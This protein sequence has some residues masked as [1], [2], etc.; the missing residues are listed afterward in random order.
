MCTRLKTEDSLV[1]IEYT[2]NL[3]LRTQLFKAQFEVDR[4]RD[5][6]TYLDD[7]LPISHTLF[8][9][10][11]KAVKTGSRAERVYLSHSD[12]DYIYEIG[13]L[14][15]YSVIDSLRRKKFTYK[16]TD[17]AGFY[18]IIDKHGCVLYPKVMQVKLAPMLG[19]T[20]PEFDSTF[21]QIAMEEKT[22][23][24]LPQ[25]QKKEDTVIAMVIGGWP[26]EIW[27]QFA[28][29]NHLWCEDI[30]AEI[31][32]CKLYLVPK[33]HPKSKH[34]SVEWRISFSAPEQVLMLHL[35]DVHRKVY[36]LCKSLCNK[37]FAEEIQSYALKTTLL[38]RLDEE[39]EEGL[40]A[41][42]Y[43][44]YY[45]MKGVF[46]KLLEFY[47]RKFLPNYFLP[48]S[49]ILCD[50]ED[51]VMETTALKIN[52][53]INNLNKIIIK[54]FKPFEL[55]NED[56]LNLIGMPI[57]ANLQS[58]WWLYS[59][60]ITEN[61]ANKDF[62]ISMFNN[63][64]LNDDYCHC[65]V[66]YELYN[67]LLFFCRC[68]REGGKFMQTPVA[69]KQKVIKH[70]LALLSEFLKDTSVG[71][72]LFFDDDLIINFVNF[73]HA[74]D[75]L[76]EAVKIIPI[77]SDVNKNMCWSANFLDGFSPEPCE[78]SLLETSQENESYNDFVIRQRRKIINYLLCAY[79]V[80]RFHSDFLPVVVYFKETCGNA[81]T[82]YNNHFVWI[83]HFLKDCRE[84]FSAF[85]IDFPFTPLTVI[86]LYTQISEESKKNLLFS[87]NEMFLLPAADGSLKLFLKNC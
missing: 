50:V 20:A 77:T 83:R 14:K 13:P 60:N 18:Q 63:E 59:H 84:N 41:S 5:C 32:K 26:H 74:L 75:K 21:K 16:R 8:P 78:V 49:N 39:S 67:I 11:T 36:L 64:Q 4:K 25:G 53:F 71:N 82:S 80:N 29:R 3:M 23:A 76:K 51:K 34:P 27:K 66:T 9:I 87:S 1:R 15:V 47:E 81:I 45:L 12:V 17:H 48:D 70:I 73:F 86:L 10:I 44:L 85:N 38:W 52:E 57:R 2:A 55:L 43:K 22:K 19:S 58:S 79:E 56:L 28:G 40:N 30:F 62:E 24:A 7:D 42:E 54:Y 31:K 65:L 72:V 69:E 68:V 33:A 61:I 37:Y 35:N 46:K 6:F